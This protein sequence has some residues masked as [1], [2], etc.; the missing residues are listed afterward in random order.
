[1]HG[2]LYPALYAVFVWWFSTG[3]ILLLDNLPRRTFRWSF[4]AGSVLFALALYRLWVSGRDVSEAGA[5]AAFTYAVIAWGWQE[6]SF[7]MGFVTGPRR[8]AAR[9]GA[10]LSERFRQGFAASLWH[11]LAILA[12]GAVIVGATWH[13]PNQ[14]GTWTFLLLWLMRTS[15]KLNVVLGVLNLGEEFLPGHLR[16]LLSFMARRPM[17]PLMPASIIL[18][19]IGTVLLTQAAFSASGAAAA[20]LTFLAAML[21]L[22][23]IEHWFLVLPLPFAR[24]WAWS[25]R[26]KPGYGKQGRTRAQGSAGRGTRHG[27]PAVLP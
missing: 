12:T 24:L 1:V 14:V 18:G 17:N 23:V 25:L 4:T 7:F 21:A 2:L 16:Y 19:T 15:A 20:G 26:F 3:I 13:A 9:P 8:D 10:A 27:L 22:A 11:E 6:M 5:Y